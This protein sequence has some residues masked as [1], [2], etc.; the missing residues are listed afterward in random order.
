MCVPSCDAIT[1]IFDITHT[2]VSLLLVDARCTVFYT[3][4]IV[5]QLVHVSAMW[6]TKKRVLATGGERGGYEEREEASKEWENWWVLWV[7]S[8]ECYEVFCRRLSFLELE[9]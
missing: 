9:L 1:I 4:D 7:G 8:L 6:G 5:H 2:G 3:Y